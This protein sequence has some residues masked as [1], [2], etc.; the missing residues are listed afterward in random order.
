MGLYGSYEVK[1][2]V[3]NPGG[4]PIQCQCGSQFSEEYPAIFQGSGILYTWMGAIET[5]Y[6]NVSCE[7]NECTLPFTEEAKKKNI[8][9]YTKSTACGEE[10]G[11]DF[12]QSV[13]KTK[14]WFTAFCD[15]MAW[16]CQTIN[17]MAS[18]FMSPKTLISWLFGWLASF[19]IDFRKSIDPWCK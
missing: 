8:F 17:I 9:L 12:I 18:P 5:H 6:H 10:M 16:R 4:T 2:A 7:A 19:K 14:I 3:V 11:W 15:E 13:M 1:H